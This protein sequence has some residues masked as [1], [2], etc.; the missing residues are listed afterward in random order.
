VGDTAVGKSAF[1]K[2]VAEKTFKE[3]DAVEVEQVPAHL[4]KSVHSAH[5]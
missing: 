5:L 1:F 3:D 4:L 2:R